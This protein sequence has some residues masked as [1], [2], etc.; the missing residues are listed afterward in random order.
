MWSPTAG[1]TR[2]EIPAIP[3][4]IAELMRDVDTTGKLVE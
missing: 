4:E 1:V 2:E 3:D